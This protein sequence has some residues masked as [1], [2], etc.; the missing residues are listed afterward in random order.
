MSVKG[1][2][3]FVPFENV[4]SMEYGNNGAPDKVTVAKV[5]GHLVGP[6]EVHQVIQEA[7][8]LAEALRSA[9]KAG[10]LREQEAVG[11]LVSTCAV[12]PEEAAGLMAET[13][14]VQEAV[15]TA[16]VRPARLSA[17]L[18]M[19]DGRTV[20]VP[21]VPPAG[22]ASAGRIKVAIPYPASAMPGL[23]VS[24]AV[25]N[26]ELG[27]IFRH[28]FPYTHAQ[29]GDALTVEFGEES[30]DAEAVARVFGEWP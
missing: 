11:H 8:P 23:V 29:A 17:D 14:S 30:L 1:Y 12:S 19:S 13:P 7:A 21:A 15:A 5:R 20:H 26:E 24:A 22:P 3:V 16:D 25:T 6:F 2:L 27:V 10:A 28:G 9:V 4:A 18:T